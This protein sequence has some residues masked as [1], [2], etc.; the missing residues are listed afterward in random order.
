[1]WVGGVEVVFCGEGI[2]IEGKGGR[3]DVGWLRLK[4]PYTKVFL[5]SVRLV[6]EFQNVDRVEVLYCESGA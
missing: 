2:E 6:I 1:M 5:E 4:S 3:F